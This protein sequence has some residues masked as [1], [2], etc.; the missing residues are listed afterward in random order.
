[1]AS[2]W[3]GR[4]T[5]EIA[6][7]RIKAIAAWRE[8][9]HLDPKDRMVWYWLG[10]QLNVAGEF[11]SSVQA[12]RR[13]VEMKGESIPADAGP[14]LARTEAYLRLE[15]RLPAVLRGEDRPKDV[16]ETILFARMCNSLQRYAATVRFYEEAF[17]TDPSLAEDPAPGEPLPLGTQSLAVASGGRTTH[18][19]TRPRVLAC[20]SKGS[21][22][23]AKNWPRSRR[24][25]RKAPN[26]L[27]APKGRPEPGP[28]SSPSCDSSSKAGRNTGT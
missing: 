26:P 19:W 12:L 4:R 20:A 21:T 11:A 13:A 22:G 10:V 8:A 17:A 9:V 7:G 23:S 5:E 18:H 1:M 28:M 14:I 25:W 3:T 16:A 27:P 2:N 24:S 15:P 6:A